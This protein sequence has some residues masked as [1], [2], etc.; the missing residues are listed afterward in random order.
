VKKG[1]A[2]ER[3]FLKTARKRF[4]RAITAE[5]RNRAAALDDL[6]F[7]AGDQ[8]DET[9]RSRREAAQRPCLTINKMPTFV[10]QVTNDQRQNRPAITVSPIGDK[11]DKHSAQM[12]RGLIR[13]IERHSNADI[14]YD[15]G[16]FNAVANGFGY[17]RIVTEYEDEDSFDQVI[18]IVRVRNPFTVYLDPDRQQPDASDA[19]WGFV[20]EMI[21]RDEF[22]MKW[23]KADKMSWEGTGIGEDYKNWL[24]EKNLRIAEYFVVEVEMKTLVYLAN[25]HVGF[26]DD[27]AD[28]LKNKITQDPEFILKE[29]ESECRKVTWYKIT[30]REILEEE[31]WAGQWIPIVECV[32]DEVD[33]EGRVTKFG[34]IRPAKDPQ[35]MVNYWKTSLTERVALDTKAPW[36]MAEGQIEGHEDEW[37]TANI[38]SRSVI[39]YKPT[40]VGG[41]LVPP[42][43]KQA[44]SGPPAGVMAAEAGAEQDMM[45]TT[46]IRF[47]ATKSERIQD[48]SGIA[49]KQL[50]GNQQLGSYNFIDNFGKAK[51]HT[52]EIIIDLVPHIYDTKRIL[53]IINEDGTDEHVQVDPHQSEAY[54]EVPQSDGKKLRSFNPNVGK[55]EVAVTI[56]PNYETLKQEA[57]SG[58]MEFGKAFPNA[59]QFIADL[60]AK[61]QPWPDSDLLAKRLAMTLPPE[62]LE[63]ERKDVTPQMQAFIS[64]LKKQLQQLTQEKQQLVQLVQ[65]KE[66]DRAVDRDKIAKNFEIGMTK[67]AADMEKNMLDHVDSRLERH[68]NAAKEMI[69]QSMQ[70]VPA[71]SPGKPN[72]NG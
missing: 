60:V 15:G 2:A 47:D 43:Q 42:P 11:G 68:F 25:G 55:Y 51:E 20:T 30:G 36:V 66:A 38:E 39:T 57:S 23:P 65:D 29:R 71:Q 54:S 1:S 44:W 3:D 49:L 67:I 18:R 16:F 21:P 26:K 46:G 59:A 5:S 64:A 35:R 53:T 63:P 40:D 50:K 22:E 69:L 56:G 58:M 27:L 28:D 12:F 48:E 70:N 37:R 6:R 7:Y 72:G 10:K 19:M 32:G 31:D 52:G 41:K 17:W 34:I 24:D 4:E 9:A 61:N 8:W 62:M 45:A 14:A 13:E 33:I